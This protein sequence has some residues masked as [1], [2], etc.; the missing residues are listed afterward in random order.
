MFL[1]SLWNRGKYWLLIA[2]VIVVALYPLSFFMHIPK[3]DSVRGYLPYRFF[4]SDYLHDGHLPLWNPFQRLGYPGYSDLQSGCWYPVVWLLNLFGQYDITTLI[5][6]AVFTFIIAGWGMFT[7]S[8]YVHRCNQTASILAISYALS[9]CMVGSA[10]L[11]VF[12]IGMAWLPWILWA[13]LHVLKG[14]GARYSAL[15]AFFLM[16]NI[17]G[18]SPA[19]TIVLMYVL[20]IMAIRYMVKSTERFSYFKRLAFQLM[21][22]AAL[23]LLLLAPFI[24]AFIDFMPY[25]NR[26]G[27]LPYEDMIIN[28]FVW[29]DYLSFVFPYSVISTHPMF[30]VTDLSLR[31]AYIG[32]AGLTFFIAAWMFRKIHTAWF[33]GLV[34]GGLLAM[35]LALG[36]Y[37][38]IYK[39]TYHLP[40]FGLF[41]HPAFFR[42]YG[43]LCMLL[44]AG[45][46][47]STW[48]KAEWH[49]PKRSFAIL[50][51][52]L[53]GV[54]V[55]SYANSTPELIAKTVSEIAQ[56][57]EFPSHGFWGQLFVNAALLTL[58]LLS[59]LLLS[60]F[61]KPSRYSLLI[62]FVVF[63][64]LLQTRLTAPTTIYHDVEYS[65]TADYFEQL[66]SLPPHD[67]SCNQA[68]LKELDESSGLLTTPLLEKNIS[69][70]NRRISCVG[71][72]PMRF[73]AFDA[74]KDSGS[75]AWVLE[76]PLMYFPTRIYFEGDSL[77]S[78]CLFGASVH[79][80]QVGDGCSLNSPRIDYNSYSAEVENPSD[81]ERWFVLN[82]NYH[83]LWQA[84]LNGKPIPIS[85][86]NQLAMGV[87]IPAFSKGQLVFRF[88]SAALP[89]AMLLS[90]LGCICV[91]LALYRTKPIDFI[92]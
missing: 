86:V 1:N 53:L 5:V 7:L 10:Q 51:T 11:M 12:L 32:I 79:L 14:D 55:L 38:G 16:C 43:L 46:A 40:G 60:R 64:L 35:W 61:R 74:A 45:F 17:T 29:S 65:T 77:R 56:C 47:M 85:R 54:S 41:R 20:P 69:T 19:F 28:P 72:N 62:L 66:E 71:E 76:N 25:F 36:D 34:I 57:G 42:G 22:T 4:V 83:H 49:F 90:A 48:L 84:E 2:G 3:W 13:W 89:W 68:A 27:K 59:I 44:L 75:L 23:L 21:V 18:A 92:G 63:D 52:V 15:L 81:H 8:R 87:Q 31:N 37:S 6:E 82:A 33:A 39:L 73:R 58:L 78:G 50:F 24:V 91:F 26:T 9:G 30:E 70:Y 88:R 80:D 67:Q